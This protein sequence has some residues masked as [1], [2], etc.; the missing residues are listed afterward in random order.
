MDKSKIKYN[1]NNKDKSN[2]AKLPGVFLKLQTLAAPHS[3]Y[4]ISEDQRDGDIQAFLGAAEKKVKSKP[5]PKK[6]DK[7]KTKLS[8]KKDK[9]KVKKDI[10]PKSKVPEK[11]EKAPTKSKKLT[12]GQNVIGASIDLINKFTELGK[13]IFHEIDT[14]TH[15]QQDLNHGTVSQTGV[16]NNLPGPPPF[17]A[18]KL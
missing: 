15:I 6:D 1:K 16:P 5:L 8:D 7:P 11:K 3:G 2:S 18:P 17:N 12:G 9:P 14:L 4:S 10:K 13:S